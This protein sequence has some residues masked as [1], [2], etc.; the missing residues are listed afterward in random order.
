MSGPSRAGWL[1]VTVVL[2]AIL[3]G[4]AASASGSPVATPNPLATC[5]GAEGSLGCLSTPAPTIPPGGL[6][7]DAAIAA[8]LRLAPDAGS[9]P[10]VIG[11]VIMQNPFVWPP[12]SSTPLVWEVLLEGSFAVSPCSSDFGAKLPSAL[13]TPCVRGNQLSAVLDMY[14]GALVGWI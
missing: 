3:T 12:T 2:A 6:S 10:V 7:R 5:G 9:Q 8:A 14:T 11:A 1:V 13:E 4:C